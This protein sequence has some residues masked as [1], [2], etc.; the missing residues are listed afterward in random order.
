MTK[1][2]RLVEIE[3]EG[4]IYTASGWSSVLTTRKVVIDA[5]TPDSEML[6]RVYAVGKRGGSGSLHYGDF[7]ATAIRSVNPLWV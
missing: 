7:G 6:Q 5:D 2:R 3:L 1:F 4:Y